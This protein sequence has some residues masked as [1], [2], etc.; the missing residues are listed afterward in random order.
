MNVMKLISRIPDDVTVRR[1]FGEPITVDDV[2]IIP[3]VRIAGGGGG[4]QGTAHP[5]E[6]TGDAGKGGSE[7]S[8]GGFG[9]SATPVGAFVVKGGDVRWEPALDVNRLVIGGQAIAIVA[10]LTLRAIMRA[11]AKRQPGARR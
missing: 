10:L 1:V 7:G 8:G 9:L 3:V 5:A 4:G 6:E 11:R 2:T